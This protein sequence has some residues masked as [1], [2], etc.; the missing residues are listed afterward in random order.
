MSARLSRRTVTFVVRIW[1]EYLEQTPPAWRG[2]VEHVGSG[3]KVYL[4]TASD[5]LEF[6]AAHT[7][8]AA[9]HSNRMEPGPATGSEAQW[10]GGE[11]DQQPD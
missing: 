2:E 3:H 1:A 11:S 7:S 10:K 8:E 9:D 4:Q 6:I 5:V